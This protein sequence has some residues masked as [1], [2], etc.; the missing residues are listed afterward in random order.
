MTEANRDS[1]CLDRLSFRPS[2][3]RIHPSVLSVRSVVKLFLLFLAEFLESGIAA[4]RVPER[5]EPKKGRCN[6]RWPRKAQLLYGVC[7][8][9]VRVEIA[10]AILTDHHLN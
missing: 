2:S 8:S 4:Q 9:R 7:N 3:G 6:R 10:T 5:I 1:A